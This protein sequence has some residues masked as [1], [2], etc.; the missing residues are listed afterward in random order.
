MLSL[1]VKAR[2][3]TSAWT[4]LTKQLNLNCS[5][6]TYIE[7][8]S[9]I[10]IYPYLLEIA[11]WDSN[12]SAIGVV[13]VEGHNLWAIDRFDLTSSEPAEASKISL[14]LWT[15]DNLEHTWDI[16]YISLAYTTPC[17]NG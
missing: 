4:G 3:A 13:H 14:I 2:N 6:A 17:I 12:G 8:K 5:Q 1:S 10:A 11:L 9:K 15:Q 16:D 7:I